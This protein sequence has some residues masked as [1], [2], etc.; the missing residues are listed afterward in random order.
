MDERGHWNFIVN[1]RLCKCKERQGNTQKHQ[2][3]V[4]ISLISDF[5]LDL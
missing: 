3:I 4:M 1:E 2:L 5:C